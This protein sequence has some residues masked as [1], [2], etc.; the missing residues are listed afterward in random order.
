MAVPHGVGSVWAQAAWEVYW[1]LVDQWGF[2]PNLYNATGSAGN[3]RMMLYVDRGPEEHGRATRR[4]RR[5][6]TASSRRRSTIT[7]A[8]TSA[9]MWDGVRRLRPGHQRRQRRRQQ[10]HA[11]QRLQRSRVL[12]GRRRHGRVQRTLR[13]QHWLDDESER[14]RY[15]NDRSWERG[16]PETT[17]SSGTKQLGT[18]TSGVNDLVTARL[19][20]ASAGV[21]D[22][23]GGVT[24]IRSPAITLPST[25]TLTLTFSSVS[26][27][28][29]QRD[30]R[31]L[32]ARERGRHDDQRRCSSGRRGGECEWRVGRGV[33]ESERRSPDRRSGC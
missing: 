23:D 30:Q 27:A 33:R 2:D 7:A 16:N 14:H 29:L 15:S 1:K 8:K 20:G 32:P 28:R 26:G 31:G 6:A 3:Q 21:N 5:S 24:S 22:V 12:P 18:T 25:G 9:A 4:S 13:D 10:H 17:D 19:A 11:D